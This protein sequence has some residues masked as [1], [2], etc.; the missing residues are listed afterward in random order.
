MK[1]EY[2][3]KLGVVGTRRDI[4]SREDALKYNNLILEKLKELE[5]DFVDITHINEEGLL[6]NEKDVE[7]IV[8]FLKQEKVDALFFPHCNFG[9]EDLVAK[10][11]KAVSKP[12]LLWGPRDEAP[13]ENGAR[14][15]DSQC[16]LFATGKILRRFKVPFSYMNMCR[17]TDPYFA[18]RLD[19]F[20]RAAQVVKELDGMTILQIGTR[21]AGFWTVMA[22]EGELIEKFNIRIHPIALPELKEEMEQV[23]LDE[24]EEA[25]DTIKKT[26]KINVSDEAVRQTAALKC[27]MKRLMDRFGCKAAAIQCWNALQGHIGLFPCVANSL[28]NE[29]GY[30]VVCETDIHGAITSLMVQAASCGEHVPFFADWTVPHPTNENG[31]LLQH[32]GPWP[33]S[34]MKEMPSFGAPFAFDYSHP[35]ALHGEIVGGDMSIVRFDGDNGE[36]KLLM[37]HAK[38]I[39]GP[40]NQGTYVW[41]EVENLKKL[42][43]KIVEGP[44]IHHCVGVHANV[45]PL[46]HEALKFIPDLRSDYYDTNDEKMDAILRGEKIC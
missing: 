31:E 39:E 37:G 33:A 11:A 25:I 43:A 40:K 44:Y 41:I 42:E 23:D 21:P 46:L 6:F 12:V 8:D 17:L 36:Y 30:P 45:L 32:C 4:F 7:A 24:I 3:L 1:R 10:V 15:R 22:N 35:G 34:L 26:M 29:E 28:L 2:N 20:L 9:T 5:I 16:G 38:G 19:N 27:A 18:W 14:L 13:L